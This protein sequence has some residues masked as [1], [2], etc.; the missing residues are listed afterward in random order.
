MSSTNPGAAARTLQ[1][2]PVPEQTRVGKFQETLDRVT[3]SAYELRS[4]SSNIADTFA[5][6][7]DSGKG[8]GINAS[9]PGLIGQWQ[10]R[11]DDLESVLSDIM[12][13][14]NR[15]DC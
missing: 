7:A 3:S 13:N 1:N 9:G 12:V 10:S 8:N 11:M 2:A 14:L 5:G 15:I 6:E 4:R